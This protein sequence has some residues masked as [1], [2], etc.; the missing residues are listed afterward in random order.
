MHSPTAEQRRYPRFPVQE[1]VRLQFEGDI[2]SVAG[3]LI[4]LS[5]G[6]AFVR[7]STPVEVGRALK[8]AFLLIH[9]GSREVVLCQGR[10]CWV[11]SPELRRTVGPGFGVRFTEIQPETLALLKIIS[12]DRLTC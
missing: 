5:V 2:A 7:C 4:N 12:H 3:C 10:V 6:G 9:Q 1:P 11:V 8:V